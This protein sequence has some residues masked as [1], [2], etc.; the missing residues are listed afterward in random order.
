MS[1]GLIAKKMKK[2]KPP[3][4]PSPEERRLKTVLF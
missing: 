1:L 2:E 4:S 3:D